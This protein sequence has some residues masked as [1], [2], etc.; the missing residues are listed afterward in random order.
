MKTRTLLV[1]NVTKLS[2]YI[3]LYKKKIFQLGQAR[4]LLQPSVKSHL[5]D[6]QSDFGNTLAL[7]QSDRGSGSHPEKCATSAAL[8]VVTS[9]TLPE[10][11]LAT[12]FKVTSALLLEGSPE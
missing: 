2:A 7:S 11:I 9:A 5:S 8:L 12:I 4:Y 6:F 1:R 10:V 3:G